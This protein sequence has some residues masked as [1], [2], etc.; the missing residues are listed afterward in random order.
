MI[1]R[2]LFKKLQRYCA[3]STMIHLTDIRSPTHDYL[4]KI[5]HYPSGQTYRTP[6]RS[7]S[8]PA[9]CSAA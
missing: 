1:A 7:T 8:S 3:L 5:D 9:R 4:L 6:N 2:L